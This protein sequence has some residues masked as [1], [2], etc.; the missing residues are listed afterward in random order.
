MVA[1]KIPSLSESK[2]LMEREIVF[3]DKPGN[4]V[5]VAEDQFS[6]ANLQPIARGNQTGGDARS[7]IAS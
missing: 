2:R 5:E 4:P 6:A 1:K 3:P 7:S